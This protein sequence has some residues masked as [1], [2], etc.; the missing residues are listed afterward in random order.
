[1]IALNIFFAVFFAAYALYA[2]KNKPRRLAAFFSVFFGGKA[3]FLRYLQDP[4]VFMNGAVP[5][6]GLFLFLFILYKI[7]DF[8]EKRGAL[9]QE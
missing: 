4:S 8:L 3:V 6:F 1:M 7:L 9:K 5:L 2:K